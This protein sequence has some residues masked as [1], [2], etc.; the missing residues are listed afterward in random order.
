[1]IFVLTVTKALSF[2]AE[3]TNSSLNKALIQLGSCDELR[4]KQK[5]CERHGS[6]HSLADPLCLATPWPLLVRVKSRDLIHSVQ[7]GLVFYDPETNCLL[8]LRIGYAFNPHFYLDRTIAFRRVLNHL[9]CRGLRLLLPNVIP[10]HKGSYQERDNGA[11]KANVEDAVNAIGVRLNDTWNVIRCHNVAK[12][13]GASRNDFLRID[14]WRM[15]RDLR[16]QTFV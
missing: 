13:G 16:A 9:L 14:R 8:H 6:E 11:R 15:L 7:I 10:A 2:S 12:S 3:C 4:Q 1:M 5:I